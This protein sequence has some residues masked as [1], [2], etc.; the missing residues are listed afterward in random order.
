MAKLQK[1][2]P[3]DPKKR[4]KPFVLRLQFDDPE[5]AEHVL[6]G[7]IVAQSNNSNEFFPEVIAGINGAL[8]DYRGAKILAEVAARG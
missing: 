3:E 8:E 4:F 6:Q 5:D 1:E 7:L 2:A